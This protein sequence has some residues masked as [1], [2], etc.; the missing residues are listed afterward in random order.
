MI[1]IKPLLIA[2]KKHQHTAKSLKKPPQNSL[3]FEVLVK[4]IEVF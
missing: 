1:D 4:K 3:K 2:D